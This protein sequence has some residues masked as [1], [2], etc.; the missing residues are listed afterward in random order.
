MVVRNYKM[1][2]NAL[3][4]VCYPKH[5]YLGIY[6]FYLFILFFHMNTV[7]K[8]LP[9]STNVLTPLPCQSHRDKCFKIHVFF[10]CHFVL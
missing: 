2:T 5:T 6:Y 3:L 4:H 9:K 7:Q 8:E 1:T 10:V